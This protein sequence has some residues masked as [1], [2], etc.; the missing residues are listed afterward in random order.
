[1]TRKNKNYVFALFSMILTFGT[2]TSAFATETKQ[3]NPRRSQW[4]A[5]QPLLDESIPNEPRVNLTQQ[6]SSK[7]PVF[8]NILPEKAE[9]AADRVIVKYKSNSASKLSKS[10]SSQIADTRQLPVTNVEL[11][12]LSAGASVSSVIEELLKDPNVLYAEPDYKVYSPINPQTFRPVE[13]EAADKASISTADA[14]QYIPDDPLFKEQWGLHNTGQV[15]NDGMVPGGKPDMD[16][17]LPEAWEITKGRKD[18]IAAV[19]GNGVKID[20]PDLVGQIWENDKEK[21]GTN[22]IDDDGNGLIDDVNGWDFAYDDN[23]LFDTIDGLND[24]Y[25]TM[26]AGH[27]AASMNNNEGIAGVA[28]NVTILPVK[29]ISKFGGYFTDVVDGI[30]YAEKNGAKIAYLGIL[31]G[32]RSKL[33]EDAINSSNMLFVAAAGDQYT[34]GTLNTDL[35]PQ[36]PA[37]YPS[38]NMLSVTGVN[39]IGDISLGAAK[40]PI[41]VDV[42]APSELI[43]S[44]VADINAGYAAEIDNPGKYKA[45]Y[46]GIGFEEVPDP[47]DQQDMFNRAMDFLK[48]SNGVQP[49]I[50]LV[51]D[52]LRSFSTG[53][54]IG[55]YDPFQIY[56]NLLTTA[57]YS[58]EVATTADETKDGPLLSKLQEYNIVVW[59]TGHLAA[60]NDHKLITTKDQAN[61]TSYL[62]GG[63]HLMLTGQ[64]AIDQIPTSDFV[65]KVLG[66]TLVKEGGYTFKT[67]GV[68]GTIYDGKEYRLMDYSLF[69]DTVISNDPAMTKINL[70]NNNGKYYYSQGTA[71]AAAYA[72]GVSALVLSQNPEMNALGIK[73]RVMN[74]GKS[75]PSLKIATVSG[76]IINAYHALWNKDIPGRS[77]IDSSVSNSLDNVTDPNHVYSIELHE[78]E[79]VTYTL[80]GSKGSDFDLILYDPSATTVTSKDGVLAY[81]ETRSTSNE[82]IT[83]IATETG[84][85][86]INIFAYNGT[87]TYTLDVHYGNSSRIIEDNDPSLL[88]NGSWSTLKDTSYSNGSLKQLNGDGEVEFGFRGN[89]FEWI[90]NKDNRQGQAVVYIDDLPV[91]YAELYSKTPLSKQS[92]FKYVLPNGHHTVKIIK[93]AGDINVDAFVIT[94]LVSPAHP[95]AN[96]VGPWATRYGTRYADLVETYTTKPN[97]SVEFTFIGTKVTLWSTTGSNRG[98]VNIYID[99]KS[100]TSQPID[101]YSEKLQYQVP[102]FTS[103]DLVNGV[104]TIKIVHAGDANPK[105]TDSVVTIDG[106]DV[107]NLN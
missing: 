5:E 64:D 14:S 7:Q 16:M 71:N 34:G 94:S 35:T 38:L 102:V 39:I 85:Y 58:Y 41:S 74:S 42:A 86:Y 33:V 98:K 44:T 89:A 83:Y 29:V 93:T 79:E 46:H 19:I 55:G 106:L 66:L 107:L 18:V 50:L 101:L 105:S 30:R 78:G 40:G 45:Y 73:Q 72:A 60:T 67:W 10:L 104:H 21:T 62:N 96:Y 12:N 27:I 2:V 43:I 84:T 8:A 63:G 13:A 53:G 88:Y 65:Q 17:N 100:V 6:N 70:R 37:A 51:Q 61:L 82:S 80:T 15:L 76:K 54:G 31:Y 36:Y 91:G 1:M 9:Y 59:E 92:L 87:G 47:Q 26:S 32:Y 48:P 28:P 20:V 4:T 49:R 3:E 95:S 97:S 103:E 68:P 77:L 22:G 11:L 75:H 99:G 56:K 25:G 24:S 52:N 23:S 90:G 57:G 81:S 69:Y